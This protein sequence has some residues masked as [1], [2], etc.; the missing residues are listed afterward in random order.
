MEFVNIAETQLEKGAQVAFEKFPEFF[1][2]YFK[3]MENKKEFCGKIPDIVEKTNKEETLRNISILEKIAKE[4]EPRVKLANKENR[5]PGIAFFVGLNNYDGH[6]FLV[7]G[8]PY[9]FLNM[10]RMN[11]MMHLK[12][13]SIKTH[14]VH[15]AFHALHYFYSPEFYPKKYTFNRKE[16]LKTL[17][18]EGVATYLS[19][20]ALKTSDAEAL[21]FGLLNEKDVSVW[22]KNCK[23]SLNTVRKKL[24]TS[25]NKSFFLS[26][27]TVSGMDTESLKNGRCGYCYGAE[28]AELAAAE[29][30]DSGILELTFKEFEKYAERYFENASP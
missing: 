21:W 25:V 20:K 2:E 4:V 24:N 12:R 17:I 15:E 19:K 29:Y 6:G 3:I 22:I 30:G 18:A 13:F 9:V 16:V 8:K 23:R 28:I 27:F 11:Q 14:L 7:N 1:T 26:L 5:F 10:T